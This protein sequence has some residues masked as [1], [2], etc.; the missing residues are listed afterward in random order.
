MDFASI[1]NIFKIRCLRIE[2]F[3]FVLGGLLFAMTFAYLC[4][5]CHQCCENRRRAR[6]KDQ[7]PQ[8]LARLSIG[9]RCPNVARTKLTHSLNMGDVY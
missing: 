7:E 5:L 9:P 2:P 8:P 6:I 1:K 4:Y 3:L